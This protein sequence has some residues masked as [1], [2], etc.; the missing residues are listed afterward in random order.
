MVKSSKEFLFCTHHVLM[1]LAWAARLPHPCWASNRGGPGG[2]AA[3]AEGVGWLAALS[4]T[5]ALDR[6][7]GRRL[8]Q[9]QVEYWTQPRPWADSNAR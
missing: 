3:K 8:P 5:E 2:W 9:V 1:M 4:R 7:M 6:A